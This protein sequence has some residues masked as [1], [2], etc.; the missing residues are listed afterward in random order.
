VCHR[1]LR[2]HWAQAAT[3]QAR[4]EALCSDPEITQQDQPGLSWRTRSALRLLF[5]PQGLKGEELKTNP[6]LPVPHADASPSLAEHVPQK[7]VY[8]PPALDMW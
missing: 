6:T 4:R 1:S 5:H 7:G 8:M 3:G 2:I